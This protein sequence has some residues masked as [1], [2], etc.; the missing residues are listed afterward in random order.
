MNP[1]NPK[2]S[3]GVILTLLGWE[4]LYKGKLEW[5]FRE[6]SG[7]K[8]TL[9]EISE[10][11]GLTPNTVA[12]VLARSE[13]VDKQTL[14]RL[15]IAFNLELN[16]SDYTKSD[17]NWER[18]QGL[19]TPKR[20]DWE[21]EVC[22]SIFYGR[23]TELALLEQW[24]ILDH[25]RVV[26]LLGMGGIGKTSLAAKL[27]HEI[28]RQFEYVIWRSLYNAPPLLDL[29]A[30]LIRFFS[31]KIILE[32]DLPN[33]VDGR[34]SQLIDYLRQHRCL[35]IL[36]NADTILQ[37]G[38]I[39]G[40]YREEYSDYGQLIKRVGQTLHQSCLL[41]TSREKPKDVASLAGEALPIRSL[42]LRGL[43]EEEA[44]RIFHSKGLSVEDSKKKTLFEQYSGN[45]LALKIVA[46]T[47]QDVFNGNISEFL[48]QKIAVFGDISALLDQQFERLSDLEREVMYWLAIN[49]EPI[50]LSQLREDIV[51]LGT[52]HRLVEALESLVRRSLI[53]KPRPTQVEKS[54]PLFTLEPVLIEYV[55]NKLI[56]QVCEEIATGESVFLRY[57]ALSKA[58]SKEYTRVAQIDFILKPIID[59]LLTIF[60]TQK[61]LEEQLTQILA[62][63]QEES[64]QEPGYTGGNLFHLFCQLHTNLRGY[65]FSNLSVWQA[66][67]RFVNLPEVNFQN[68]NL[69]KSLFTKNFSRISAV[70]FSPNGKTLAT[71]NANGK[72]CLWQDF[73]V[74][75]SLPSGIN[76]QLLIYQR[77]IG[78]VRAI[79]FCPD[80]SIIGSGGT[81]QNV[82]LWD[83]S[84][85]EC[86]KTLRGHHKRVQAVA[87]NSKGNILACGSDDQTVSLWNVNT[88]K[89]HKILQGHTGRVLSVVF[90][91]QGKTLASASSDE[92]VRLWNISTGQCYKILK[93]HIGWVWSVT[94][95]PDGKTLASGSDDQSVKFWDVSSDKCL[96]TLRGHSNRVR[97]VTFAPKD[98]ILASGSDDQ[99]VKLWD[100]SSGECLRTLQGHTDKIWSVAFSPEGNILASASD[101]QTVRLWDVSTGQTLRIL[102]GYSNG[103]MSVAFAPGGKTF[104]S[105]SDDQ[106]VHC[107]D[108]TTGQ[109]NKAFQGH[110]NRVR[111]V[112][113]S[114]DGNILATGSY[115]QVVRLWDT[116]T[117]QSCK[118]LQGHT[119]WI[120]SVAF[121]PEGN[122]LASGSD[123]QTVRLWDVNT[124]EVLRTLEHSHG[125]WSVAF[126]PEGN[127]LASGCD[128]QTV[129]LWNVSTGQVL[130]TLSGHSGWVLSVAFSP[131]GKTLAS[132]SKDKT[133]RLWD[134][135]THQCLKT[136]SGHTSWILSVAFSPQGNIL[137]SGSVDQMVKLWDIS[138]GQ[139]IKTLQSHTHWIRSVAFSPDGLTLLSGSEDGTVKLWDVLTGECLKTFRNERPYEGM[140]ITGVTGLTEA[141]IASL[142]ALGAIKY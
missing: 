3:R 103:V 51:S 24:L 6:K 25:C 107:W 78:W 131:E 81:N 100:A 96:R 12:K 5:E 69:S 128:D 63:L 121:A 45:P 80:G 99:T 127:I 38:A 123:D 57:Y 2:R 114:P 89:C 13:G 66:D 17:S 87:F 92:T 64:P 133:V 83:T 77:H 59:E 104:V 132:G 124:G 53:H 48:N 41:L 34:I 120:K 109:C 119:G 110:A 98:K 71:S 129:S 95:S 4:K 72:I 50:T 26:A 136:F 117:N 46:T 91:P 94:F 62:K 22:V 23:T 82:K 11:A 33:S 134:F 1:H 122:I 116:S 112:A 9:E 74:G 32:A 65:D 68:A 43:Y 84:S 27:V 40:S 135:S 15:F 139:C 29:L 97:S 130:K 108:V 18:L 7:S 42:Q 73:A 14:V 10:R 138:T 67:L 39:A 20:I 113:F 60:K 118:I 106:T 8:Y 58:Q 140:N 105:S 115:D 35:M 52:P 126:S 141:T 88:S 31:N 56:K 85:G 86:L 55:T 101:D 30:N 37:S 16:K 21:E 70:A 79:A 49:R 142:K 61:K 125:V 75:D 28:Q 54:A 47:I 93:G 36:D 111:T 44:K 137:A 76:E 90:S 102:Q 19:K